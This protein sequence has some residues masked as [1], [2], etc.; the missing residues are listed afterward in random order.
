[1]KNEN[2]K[3]NNNKGSILAYVLVMM[4]IVSIILIS[5]LQY[6]S[7]QIKLGSYRLEKEKAFH[8]AEA[9]IY[10]YRWYL[11]HNI[12]GKTTQQINDFWDGGA[13]GTAEGGDTFDF[14][15]PGDGT[16]IGRYTI[17]VIPPTDGSTIVMVKSTGWTDKEPDAKRV[18]QARF[19]RPSWSEYMFLSDTFIRFGDQAEVYGK[20]HSNTGIRF[21][22]LAHSLVTSSVSSFNDPDH[23]GG[24]EFGV[25]THNSSVDPLP[26]AAVP[27]RSDVFMG[28]R[29]FPVSDV[30]FGGVSA[31]LAAMKSKAMGGGGKYFAP[32][33]DTDGVRII[34]KNNTYDVCVVDTSHHVNYSISK[35]KRNSGTG[36]CSSCSGACVTNYP[37][38]NNGIIFV[39]GN[40][41][42]E[43]TVDGKRVSVVAANLTGSGDLANIYIGLGNMRYTSYTCSNIV[44]LIAQQDI[45]VAKDC[46]DDFIIDAAVLAQSGRVGISSNM[47]NKNS[48]TFNGAIASY[49][50]PFFAHS[51]GFA[52]RFY[53]F[54]NNMLYCP[55]PDFPT[56]TEYA[57]DLWEEL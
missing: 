1:M 4:M 11:A 3:L 14:V 15:D 48:L 31:D 17:E 57:I 38:L 46:P 2:K 56:G 55:P 23:G 39:E 50:Q 20:V 36:T 30:D 27:N 47:S 8:V 5:M 37:I 24:L 9:G 7:S 29:E 33:A 49:L 51:G 34:F 10:Y 42:V 19:R 26:P 35:Y 53:N 13:V 45:T 44:G 41:W 21:D 54:D 43:G 18:V 40:A 22:G 12:S 52:V 32:I 28:G 25:H 16:V 6:I